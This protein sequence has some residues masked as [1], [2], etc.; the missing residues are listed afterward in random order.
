MECME[1]PP[2][3]ASYCSWVKHLFLVCWTY[4]QYEHGLVL[5]LLKTAAAVRVRTTSCAHLLR[6]MSTGFRR[7]CYMLPV[8]GG[9]QSVNRL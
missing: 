3:E 7:V 1:A 5:K 8:R 2:P 9:S 4:F 6:Q